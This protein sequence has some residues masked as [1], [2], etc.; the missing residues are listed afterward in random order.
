MTG[1]A[2]LSRRA[3]EL[4]RN[5]VLDAATEL[6]IAYGTAQTS[7]DAIAQ[8]AGVAKGTVYLY[9]SSKDE[10]L[11]ELE[12]RFNARLMHRTREASL[13]A[14]TL[15]EA[16]QAWCE[17]LAIAYLDEI[18]VHDMLFY[19][20][21][22]ARREDMADNPLIDQLSV[23]LASQGATDPTATA[24]F[25][26]GGTIHVIDRAVGNG[27]VTDRPPVMRTIRR[28]VTAAVTA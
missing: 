15:A 1:R 9:F 8:S 24:A 10:I 11:Q 17:A 25:L 21:S 18:E 5:A 27:P 26:L 14:D 4:R 16:A 23:L 12:T 3:P 7:I 28:L 19:G 20:R 13:Q 22:A 2:P 6:F